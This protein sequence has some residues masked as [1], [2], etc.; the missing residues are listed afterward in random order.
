MIESFFKI[1]PDYYNDNSKEVK[2][3]LLNRVKDKND[4]LSNIAPST[5]IHFN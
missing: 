3:I 4:I 2:K 5:F 1:L